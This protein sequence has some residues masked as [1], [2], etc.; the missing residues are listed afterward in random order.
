VARKLAHSDRFAFA[1]TIAPAARSVDVVLYEHRNAVQGTADLALP[2]F[3]V[4]LVRGLHPVWAGGQHRVQPGT[5]LV[6]LSYAS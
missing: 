3:G 5:C 2:A 1:M 4:Q 6:G